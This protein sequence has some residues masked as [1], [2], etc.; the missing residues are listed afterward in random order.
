[1]TAPV[2]VS[3]RSTDPTV[4]YEKRARVGFVVEASSMT[5]AKSSVPLSSWSLPFA[6][7]PM[8]NVGVAPNGKS[9]VTSA[10][11]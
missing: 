7:A 10:A 8:S 1:V 9:A 5:N 2:D 3:K 4:V 11:E 6:V